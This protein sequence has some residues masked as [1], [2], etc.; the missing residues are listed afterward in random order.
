MKSNVLSRILP[1]AGS[2]SVYEAIREH[3]ADSN[4]SDVEDRAGMAWGEDHRGEQYNDEELEEA[5]ADAQGSQLSSPTD[6]TTAFLAEDRPYTT[7][8]G[9][10]K[11]KG[12]GKVAARRRKSSRPR[13][14]QDA[15]PGH[16]AEDADDDVPASLM[17]EENQEDDELRARLPPPHINTHQDLP[18]PGPSRDSRSRWGTAGTA[19]EQ[20]L[21]DDLYQTPPPA[22]R[23]SIG[24]HPNLA[25][26]DPKEKAM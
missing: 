10:N 20:G 15:L 6:S 26:A 5:M 16:E 18:E 12:K 17:V 24:Q 1:P 23:W 4:P 22:A 11:G 21:H 14:T 8:E 25:F 2:P 13:W 19:R 3:D 7:S 9:K